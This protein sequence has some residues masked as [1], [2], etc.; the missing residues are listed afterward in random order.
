MSSYSL[1][2]VLPSCCIWGL[3]KVKF[4]YLLVTEDPYSHRPL[5]FLGLSNEGYAQVLHTGGRTLDDDEF[6]A[7]K[8]AW[9]AICSPDPKEA[10]RCRKNTPPKLTLVFER[11][12]HMRRH[13]PSLRTG[14]NDFEYRL[15]QIC[16]K[17]GP[18][19]VAICVEYVVYDHDEFDRL[20]DDILHATLLKL[21]SD[22][23][24]HPLLKLEGDT[25]RTSFLHRQ[26]DRCREG[27]FAG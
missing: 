17:C 16:A 27:C 22:E 7:L 23:L 8:E 9:H 1:C 11:I 15:L 4:R 18:R 6:A 14:L 3:I 12:D 24:N 20:G 21:A 25:K 5:S 26:T 2:G 19:A 10:T 13:Y